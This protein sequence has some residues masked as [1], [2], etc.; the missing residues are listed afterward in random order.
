[1]DTDDNGT[2]DAEELARHQDRQM[3][4]L[5]DNRDGVIAMQKI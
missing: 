3:S 4:R 5:D 2:V 1:M